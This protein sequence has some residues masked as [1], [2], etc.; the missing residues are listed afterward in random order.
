MEVQVKLL[1]V[2]AAWDISRFMSAPYRVTA[3]ILQI[4]KKKEAC[5]RVMAQISHLPKVRLVDVFHNTALVLDHL[6]Y[7]ASDEVGM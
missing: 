2:V 4:L 7:L 6:C 3:L 5:V 1:D